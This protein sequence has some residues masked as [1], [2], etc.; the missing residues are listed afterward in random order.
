MKKIL[1][2][3]LLL[4]FANSFAQVPK[5]MDSLTVF[6]K[7]K[8]QDTTYI[9]ALNEYA[10]L[11]VQEGKIEDA[12]K[13]IAQMDK[14]SI[15]FN[16]GI[17]IYS[18]QNMKGVIEYSNQNPQKAMECFLESTKIIEKYKLP[19][20]KYQ[21]ALNNIGIIYNQLGDRENATK[22]SIKLI[23]FQEK[24]KLKPLKTNPYNQ[25]GNNL[26]FYKKYDEALGYFNKALTIETDLKNF[27]G[28]AIC[29]NNIGNLN[30]DIKKNKKAIRHY[31]KGLKYAE[32]ANYKLLQTD[33]LTN[34]GR[35]Y[36]KAKDYPKAEKYLKKSEGFCRELETTQ[37]LKIVCSNLGD[38]Y[39]A[40]KK[41][42]LAE[43]Y[44]QEALALSND[45]EDMEYQYTAN[46]NLSELYEVKKDFKKALA[47][48]Q[49]AE[50]EKDSINKIDIAKNTEDLLRK[51]ETEKKEQKI[52]QLSTQNTIKNLQISNSN[53]QK[54]FLLSGILL[55]AIIGSLLFYQSQN[56]QKNNEKLQL[57][58]TDLDE[59]NKAKTRFFSILNHD[60]R[61]PVANLIFFLQL[62]KESPEM[63]DEE[64]TKRM[65]DKTME[66]A[67]NLLNSMEDIL[68]WSKS[69]MENFK[70]QP[71]KIYISSLFE[72]T[73]KH[74]SSEE[75]IKISYENPENLQLNTDENYLKT[76][77]RNL[78]GNAIKALK[79]TESPLI[80][81]K[82]WKE[83]NQ[84]FLS[85]TDNGKGASNEQF[86]ALYDDKEISG[87]KTGLGFHLIRDL[88]KA[89][90][91]K[92]EV[93]SKLN[94]GTIFILN[95]KK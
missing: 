70:P 72:D 58:N 20:K 77:I 56:R 68:Q 23:N 1:L 4:T 35:L 65:Q 84:T 73:Q 95:F 67:E 88:A 45:F 30:E 38:M 91:C 85:I 26:K 8:P 48:K 89:I 92:I 40:Q 52:N 82:T 27:I 47:Y 60:L 83:N 14:L 9:L 16:F 66:G 31:E 61:G 29:E 75:N 11:L 87:I 39:F 44:Y 21:N 5:S 49:A 90:D 81:W 71:T 93:E 18:V 79:E 2:L 17:G 36:Q 46:Q 57:L 76:I 7:T 42:G 54:W 28:M 62:Q 59:A 34:L 25:L 37:S 12:K 6:L 63:L 78:T 15:K 24:N 69:Q 94:E 43:K 19:K 3:F 33:L 13:S 50:V 55:L 51:Y 22:Y 86:K 32:D 41:Y 53:K 10:F 80:I 64:S 74:F